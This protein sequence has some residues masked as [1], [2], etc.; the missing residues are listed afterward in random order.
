MDGMEGRA[1]MA[2]AHQHHMKMNMLSVPAML[3]WVAGTY[4]LL[5]GA[6]WLTAR[7]ASI[8]F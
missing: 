5:F 4:L 6:I 7:W 3:L 1:D 8:S 2:G